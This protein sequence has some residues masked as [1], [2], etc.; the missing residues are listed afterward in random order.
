MECYAKI[1]KYLTLVRMKGRAAETHY[2]KGKQSTY[3]E[4]MRRLNE[5]K[6][7]TNAKA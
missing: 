2:P 3:A 7:F 6:E 4:T 5:R 1:T